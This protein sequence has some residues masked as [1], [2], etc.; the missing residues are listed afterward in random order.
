MKKTREFLKLSTF[1]IIIYSFATAILAGALLLCLPIATRDGSG[2]K[3]LDALFTSVSAVC[4]TGLVV[5]DTWQYWSLFGRTVIILL[6]QIGGLGII[7]VT[8]LIF[9]ISGKK[10][11][12][13]QRLIMKDAI[14]ADK[15]GGILRLTSFIFRF[16]FFTELLGAAL[17][18][19]VFIREY[20]IL[21]G[22]GFS[23]F[24]SVSAF[25]NA[26]FDLEGKYGAFS[27]LCPYYQSPLINLVIVCLI[28]TGGLGFLTWKDIINNKWHLT[29]YSLQSK[30]ILIMTLILISVPALYFYHAEYS[31]LPFAERF[32]ASLFQSVT[33][34]T[35]GFNT[36]D[37]TALTQNGR[38]VMMILM[39]IGGAPGSTAGGMKVTTI[40]VLIASSI[41]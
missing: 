24:H 19:P 7:T 35:A 25:C 21:K 18:S 30:G 36:K 41:S 20:G 22:I 34:R 17:L 10:I 31:G 38:I 32:F 13:G 15:V 12:L 5:K 23:V 4:V 27:S 9:I 6:I 8:L 33:T 16:T 11:S 2:A 37:L 39:L 28:V 26:G 14:S 29:R 40:L 1:Q 3:F